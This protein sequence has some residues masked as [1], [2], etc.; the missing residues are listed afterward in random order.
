MYLRVNIEVIN[1][2]M[3]VPVIRRTASAIL[4]ELEADQDT[5]DRMKLVVTEACSNVIKHA[6]DK[7]AMYEVGLEYC[8]EMVR[9]TI[10]DYGKGFTVEELPTPIY[11]TPQIGGYGISFIK[12]ESSN[13]VIESTPEDGTTIRMEIPVT[14]HNKKVELK[15]KELPSL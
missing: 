13:I 10:K 2:K 12:R 3:L 5:I 11:G 4:E 1:N 8:A 15:L 14:Y 7:S 9:I 6:Y